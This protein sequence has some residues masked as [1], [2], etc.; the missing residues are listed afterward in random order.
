M[1]RFCKIAAFCLVLVMAAVI[2]CGCGAKE[3]YDEAIAA[4]KTGCEKTLAKES[5]DIYVYKMIN[6]TKH[7]SDSYKNVGCTGVPSSML[8][9]IM[10]SK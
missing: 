10:Y 3:N 5:G 6:P 9:S 7:H 4:V 2:A 8:C 1:K